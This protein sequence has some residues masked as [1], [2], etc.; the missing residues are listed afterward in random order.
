MAYDPERVRRIYDR[1]GGRC[2]AC[3]KRLS[4][5]NYGKSGYRGAWEVDHSYARALGGT[6][7][8]NNLYAACVSCNRSKGTLRS[9][10]VRSYHG[11]SRAP[12]PMER[13]QKVRRAR[14][15]LGGGLG[16][17]IGAGVAGPPGFWLG[18]VLGAAIG[19]S[20]DPDRQ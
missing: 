3:G 9:R 20:S 4:F 12:L 14:A 6:D 10:T 18:G 2:H 8:L 15:L 16:G 19:Y 11:R 5:I 7:H 13:R 1:T 17:L